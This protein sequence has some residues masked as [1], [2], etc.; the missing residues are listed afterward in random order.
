MAELVAKGAFKMTTCQL[1]V[2]DAE[3]AIL[4]KLEK[5]PEK[6]DAVLKLWSDMIKKIDL[7]I[8]PDPEF[9]VVKETFDKYMG[10]MRHKAD[11]LFLAAALTMERPPHA[12]LSGNR[13][14]FNDKVSERCKI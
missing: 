6:L 2:D 4:K 1:V 9:P 10:V 8:M 13:E 7:E 5:H 11:I 14:H 12:I 3:N